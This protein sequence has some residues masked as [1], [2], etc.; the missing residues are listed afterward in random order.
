MPRPIVFPSNRTAVMGKLEDVRVWRGGA[1]PL[2]EFKNL[3]SSLKE[4]FFCLVH[5]LVSFLITLAFE[6]VSVY[7]SRLDTNTFR[8]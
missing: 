2:L 8:N 4:F 6:G 5:I 7:C 3:Y 1:V